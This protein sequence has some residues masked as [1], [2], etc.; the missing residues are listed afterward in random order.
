[1]STPEKNT[2]DDFHMD[3]LVKQVTEGVT[4]AEQ[5]ALE[6]L[7]PA[8]RSRQ[9]AEL[10]R[11]AAAITVAGSARLA[12]LPPALRARLE[13]SARTFVA[14]AGSAPAAGAAT[15][16]GAGKAPDTVRSLP[17]RRPAVS[18]D[19]W[20]AA[21]ACLVLAVFAWLRVPAPPSRAAVS[22][23]AERAALL[24]QTGSLKIEAAGTQ[25][26]AAVGARVDVVWD[27][28][29]QRGYLRF[30][31]LAPNDPKVN[32]YQIWIFDGEGDPRYP[33]DGGVFD[34]PA[35]AREV[36]VPIHAA[37]R[38]HNAKAFAVTVERPGGVVV[39]ARGRVVALAQAT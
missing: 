3:L 11:A 27:P 36:L 12:P 31:G 28:V 37:I 5:R 26:P 6:S 4:P 2:P 14:E 20:W 13:E 23:A 32:Q 39:S 34:V 7:D 19:G 10:E 18:L 8:V 25:D 1:M 29:S 21:A 38:V 35:D 30:V 15:A 24:A 9:I 16:A 33:V 22:P 17:L